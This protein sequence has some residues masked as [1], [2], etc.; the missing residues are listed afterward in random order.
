M[1]KQQ[2]FHG[3]SFSGE[4]NQPK[5]FIWLSFKQQIRRKYSKSLMLIS[6]KTGHKHI[7][8]MGGVGRRRYLKTTEYFA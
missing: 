8:K 2:L 1:Y 3:K 7:G 6:L 4:S 5:S